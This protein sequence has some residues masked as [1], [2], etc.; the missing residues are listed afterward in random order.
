MTISPW[1]VIDGVRGRYI[2]NRNCSYVAEFLIKTGKSHIEPEIEALCGIAESLPPG[3]IIVDAGASHGL[4]S[5]PL[6]KAVKAK[7]GVVYCYEVQQPFV[8]AL[9]GTVLLNDLPNMF[10]VFAGL[11]D[12]IG[13]ADYP[14]IDYHEPQD[15]GLVSLKKSDSKE[16]RRVVVQAIDSLNLGRLDLL[17]IDVEGMEYQ[18]LTGARRSLVEYRPW[19]WLEYFKSDVKQLK[20]AF[21]GLDYSFFRMD[22]QNMLAAP[23]KRLVESGIRIEAEEM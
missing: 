9:F 19:V 21:S 14:K 4:I 18:V 8:M 6:A 2:I 20:S 3:C 5:V 11:S 23:R 1:T 15:F 13:F 22:R 17:K 10:P 12:D 7:G 16:S